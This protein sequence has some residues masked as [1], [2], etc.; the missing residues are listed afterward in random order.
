MVY[1]GRLRAQKESA[2]EE[3]MQNDSVHRKMMRRKIGI[4]RKGAPPMY[5]EAPLKLCVAA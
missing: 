3:H 5:R 1:P 2:Q 4:R